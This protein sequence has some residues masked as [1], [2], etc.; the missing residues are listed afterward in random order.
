VSTQKR[1]ATALGKDAP[2]VIALHDL[3]HTHATQ[4]LRHAVPVKIV[5]ER[6]GHASVVITLSIYAHVLPGDQERAAAV[7]AALIGEEVAA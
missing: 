5:S 1:C 2:P 4:L 6:L 7:S 3:R